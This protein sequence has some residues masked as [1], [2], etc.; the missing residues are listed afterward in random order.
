MWAGPAHCRHAVF[1]KVGLGCSRKLAEHEP[2]SWPASHV[3]PWLLL[4]FRPDLPK[5]WIVKVATWKG[6]LKS[7]CSFRPVSLVTEF[8]T[9][10][11]KSKPD[12]ILRSELTSI[13]L[14]E[15]WCALGVSQERTHCDAVQGARAE[16]KDEGLSLIDSLVGGISPPSHVYLVGVGER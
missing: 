11:Q 1:G 10:Q 16:S 5:S 8:T 4:Q 13:H 9:Q 2:E 14:E 7:T 15:A 12:R 3:L 6:N